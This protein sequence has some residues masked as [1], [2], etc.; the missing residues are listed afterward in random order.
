MFE[1][2]GVWQSRSNPNQSDRINR[3][4]LAS[5]RE[6][7]GSGRRP[8][9]AIPDL[10]SSDRLFQASPQRAY[11]EAW[12]LTFYLCESEP[13]KYFAYLAK[14]AGR[15]AF[16]SYRG[17]ER[18]KDFT[19]VFE[20]ATRTA[21]HVIA[22]VLSKA[23]SGTFTNAEQAARGF[24]GR[25]TVVNG[26]SAS[27][28]QGLL[29]MRGVELAA[30]GWAPA[31][32]VAELERVRGQSGVFLTIEDFERLVA[33]SRLPDAMDNLRTSQRAAVDVYAAMPDLARAMFT[34]AAI[35][36]DAV[37]AVRAIEDGRRPGMVHLARLL[38]AQ[39][40]LRDDVTVEE[41]VDILTV[42]TSF[43]SFDELFTGSGL[44]AG[45]VA[46]RLIAMAVRS[47]CRPDA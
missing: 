17:P 46:E 22:V 8:T 14:T 6:Y 28:G 32:I 27:L 45:V 5:F 33:A 20:D 7:V 1:S 13:R 15:P 41:A 47:V 25:L 43:Q 11:P 18:L 16:S 24:A 40:Y 39:G 31:A 30:Q 2:R 26:R 12:A 35:D 29:V 21:D 37:A 19:D 34:M 38:Q 9:S 10:I 4:L 3:Q 23:L 36:P 42:V 44:P